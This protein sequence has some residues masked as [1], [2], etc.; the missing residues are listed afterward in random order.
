MDRKY[1]ETVVRLGVERELVGVLSPPV[2]SSVGVILLNAGAVH[3][4]GPNRVYVT[5]ARAL[6]GMGIQVLRFDLSGVGDSAGSRSNTSRADRW[7]EEVRSAVDLMTE[8]GVERVVLMG[9]C[10]GADLGLEAAAADRR[11]AGAVLVNATPC[12][13]QLLPHQ[14]ERAA[15]R[16]AARYYRSRLT[17]PDFW[18]RLLRGQLRLDSAAQTLRRFA[19]G[20]TRKA[21]TLGASSRVTKQAS[22]GTPA[23]IPSLESLNERAVPVLL[24]YSDG[25]VCWDA[26]DIAVGGLSTYV[27]SL[28]HV[29]L[30]VVAECDHVFT[31]VESQNYLVD[32][33][34]GWLARTVLPRSARKSRGGFTATGPR[35]LPQASGFAEA[36]F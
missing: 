30:Q 9:I 20:V 23:T 27:E 28:E 31:M 4:A 12:E 32:T 14:F 34:L 5:L 2:Q 6:A 16:T 36:N 24:L 7:L 25:S 22:G 26:T 17:R 35:G 33:T 8:R 3:R 21:A 1:T 13:K 10:S 29:V 19:V 18:R 11:I 15:Q